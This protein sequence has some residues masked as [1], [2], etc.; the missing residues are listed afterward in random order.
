M[1]QYESLYMHCHIMPP[2]VVLF[3]ESA[4]ATLGTNVSRNSR[5]NISYMITI[6][7]QSGPRLLALFT[8][9]M[10]ESFTR[11]ILTVPIPKYMSAKFPITSVNPLA[12]AT[13]ISLKRG[14]NKTNIMTKVQKH[15]TFLP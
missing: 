1:V 14:T 9:K 3:K 2:K 4:A 5:M 13:F 15:F 7:Y 12:F 8:F 6:L 11:V 10:P